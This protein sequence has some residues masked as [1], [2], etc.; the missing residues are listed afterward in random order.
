[1]VLLDSSNCLSSQGGD[2]GRVVHAQSCAPFSGGRLTHLGL[3]F[4]CLGDDQALAAGRVGH[5]EAPDGGNHVLIAS[6]HVMQV[7]A[8]AAEEQM[9]NLIPVAG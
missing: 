9:Q 1:M 4:R 2:P 8:K 7:P 5:G 6:G 3:G